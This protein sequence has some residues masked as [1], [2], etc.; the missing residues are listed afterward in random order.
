MSQGLKSTKKMN[1]SALLR[2]NLQTYNIQVAWVVQMLR[3]PDNRHPRPQSSTRLNNFVAFDQE[4]K[5]N[6]FIEGRLCFNFYILYD[7]M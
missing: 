2:D 6:F 1:F 5:F 4:S 3:Q 7:F